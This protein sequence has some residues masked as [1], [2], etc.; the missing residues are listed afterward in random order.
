M[1]RDCMLISVVALVALGVLLYAGH[2]GVIDDA[3]RVA[4]VPTMA[5]RVVI[6][7]GL[8]RALSLREF[9]YKGKRCLWATLGRHA[10]LTCWEV[11]K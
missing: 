1:Y 7:D 6:E 9:N 2:T 11:T 3:K 5:E 8:S 10:G 4:R